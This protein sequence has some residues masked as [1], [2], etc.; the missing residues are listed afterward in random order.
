MMFSKEVGTC[1]GY[2][3]LR[4]FGGLGILKEKKRVYIYIYIYTNNVRAPL[5]P[6]T[7]IEAKKEGI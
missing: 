2:S 7:G 5:H 3:T 1:P 6:E 4:V